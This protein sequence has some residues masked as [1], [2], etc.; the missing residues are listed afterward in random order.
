MLCFHWFYLDLLPSVW[1]WKWVIQIYCI[2]VFCVCHFD[3][4][5]VSGSKSKF[6]SPVPFSAS[7]G[8]WHPVPYLC[9]SK[10][11][12]S[13]KRTHGMPLT[14]ESLV[15]TKSP[16]S[17]NGDITTHCRGPLI[18]VRP[19]SCQRTGWLRHSYRGLGG[20]RELASVH[21]QRMLLNSL[22]VTT[23]WLLSGGFDAFA[24]QHLRLYPGP[25]ERY[26]Q[27]SRHCRGLKYFVKLR[28]LRM[29]PYSNFQAGHWSVG[30][31]ELM[32]SVLIFLLS[33]G[34]SVCILK[35]RCFARNCKTPYLRRAARQNEPC[36]PGWHRRRTKQSCGGNSAK[37][38]RNKIRG[39]ISSS[40]HQTQKGTSIQRKTKSAHVTSSGFL[41]L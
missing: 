4:W 14:G 27:K 7:P 31:G 26:A 13:W 33:V 36:E 38:G 15:L 34:S 18:T 40:L 41:P 19:L 10:K 20:G 9:S 17:V 2:H 16:C 24:A 6:F 22:A 11:P 5:D 37:R 1:L 35:L 21:R 12:H 32:L 29:N 23:E 8:R 28:M 25:R 30:G 39:V 3:P